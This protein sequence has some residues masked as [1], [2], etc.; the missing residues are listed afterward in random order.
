MTGAPTDDGCKTIDPEWLAQWCVFWGELPNGPAHAALAATTLRKQAA[1][2]ERLRAVIADIAK[3]TD[4]GM[5]FTARREA[6]KEL[7]HG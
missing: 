7:G 1:E 6:L 4:C 2:I 3:A 5:Y